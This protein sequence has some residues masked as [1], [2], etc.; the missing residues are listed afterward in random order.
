MTTKK[1]QLLWLILAAL[2]TGLMAWFVQSEATIT[3]IAGAFTSVVGVFLGLDIAGMIRKTQLLPDGKYK[4]MNRSRYIAA[5]IIFGILLAEA[6]CLS[7][8]YERNMDTLYLCFGVGFII[9]IG[10]MVS[11]I[12]GNKIVTGEVTEESK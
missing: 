2:F 11:G 3:A 6:F 1:S 7:V 10:G 4:D 12:E 5:I 9:V 8:L